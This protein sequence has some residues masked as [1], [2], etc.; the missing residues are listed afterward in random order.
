M[1]VL[2]PVGIGLGKAVGDEA[3]LPVI[4]H[5]QSLLGQGLH[6]HEPLGG[7][8]GLHVVVAAVAGA[9]V[10]GVVLDLL[11]QAQGLQ[12]GHHGLAGLVPVHA[13]ILAAVLVHL[14]V[15]VQDADGV[16]IVAQAHLKVVGVVGGVIFT[17]P[18]PKSIST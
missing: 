13:L 10:V 18:V 15:V 12:V 11:H 1:D 3:G 8:D 16:Q 2:H 7:D 4:H 5:P 17:Q 9:H 6:L 14:A